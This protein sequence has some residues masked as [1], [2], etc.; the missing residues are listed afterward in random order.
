[1]SKGQPLGILKNAHHARQ[2]TEQDLTGRF[3]VKSAISGISLPSQTGRSDVSHGRRHSD[4]ARFDLDVEDNMTSAFFMDDITLESRKRA[5]QMQKTTK[6]IPTL[7]RDAKR[8]LDSLCVDHDCRNCF[9][10]VRINSHKHEDDMTSDG[11]NKKTTVRVEKPIP[12][13]DRVPNPVSAVGSDYEDQPTMRPSQD[14][15]VALAT[16]L[17]GLQDEA[18]HIKSRLAEKQAKLSAL[19]PSFGRRQRK[20]LTSEINHL[21]RMLDLKWDQIYALNDV[22]EGQKTSGQLMT[23]QEVEIT[24]ASIMSKDHTWDGIMD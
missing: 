10:C 12:V 9:V 13:T 8:V 6:A 14:P 16:V 5:A 23:E 18:A 22:L 1:M 4:S 17:K 7:S 24:V 11:A 2:A 20:Q 15:G 21:M 19:D 3:S